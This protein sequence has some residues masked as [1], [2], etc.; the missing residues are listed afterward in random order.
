MNTTHWHQMF[1]DIRNKNQ[2]PVFAEVFFN[3]S[4]KDFTLTVVLEGRDTKRGVFILVSVV[5]GNP[6][7]FIP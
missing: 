6:G 2:I 5:K 7:R 1:S 3:S 4:C